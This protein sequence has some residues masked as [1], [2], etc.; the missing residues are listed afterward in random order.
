MSDPRQ[1]QFW[2]DETGELWDALHELLTVTLLDGVAEGV[3]ALPQNFRVLA[4]YD[5]VN[6]AVLD[7]VRDY[8][9]NWI[10]KITDTTRSQVQQAIMDWMREGSPLDALATRLEP[11]FGQARA[12][13]IAVTE[14]TRV[15]AAGNQAAWEST[16]VVSKVIW[17]TGNDELVCAQCG[18]LNDVEIGIGDIDAMPPA[19][20]RCRCYTRP[21]VDEEASARK[22]AE[23]F[24]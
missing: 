5:L 22:F 21:F 19:H 23:I 14:V 18:P 9:F 1:P 2:E 8:R 24:K 13:S 15:Y 16:G 3:E 20:P 11:V 10:K 4:D 6:Q 7:Y 12:E 17:H